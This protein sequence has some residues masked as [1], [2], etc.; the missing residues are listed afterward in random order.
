MLHRV[1]AVSFRSCICKFCARV[2]LVTLWITLMAVHHFLQR[3]L[4][5]AVY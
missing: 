1:I 2:I 4:L 5:A 3:N